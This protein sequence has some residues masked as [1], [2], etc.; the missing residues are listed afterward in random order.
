[1]MLPV[2][3]TGFSANIPIITIAM[4]PPTIRDE[5]LPVLLRQRDE[6]PVD[7]ADNAERHHHRDEVPGGVRQDGQAEAEEPVVPFFRAQLPE[8]PSRPWARRCA[9]LAATCEM[10]T[11]AL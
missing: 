7:D 8:S 5:P 3:P 9:R 10:E 6:R 4:W 2:M 11:S 1:M